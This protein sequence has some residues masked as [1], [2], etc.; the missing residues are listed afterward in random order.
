MCKC[1]N[2]WE[3]CKCENVQMCKWS[4]LQATFSNQDIKTFAH[5]HICTLTKHLHIN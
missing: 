1:A 4:P 3:M 2:A 5:P